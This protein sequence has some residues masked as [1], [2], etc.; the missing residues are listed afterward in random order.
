M[1]NISNALSNLELALEGQS[2][3]LAMT[4]RSS[5]PTECIKLIHR[6]E[7]SWQQMLATHRRLIRLAKVL[8]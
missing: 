3:A 6:V 5:D 1:T 7:R 8:A 2:A 4:E